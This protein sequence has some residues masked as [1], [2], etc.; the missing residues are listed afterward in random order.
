MLGHYA[1]LGLLEGDVLGLGEGDRS[2]SEEVAHEGALELAGGGDDAAS[3][4]DG[5]LDGGEDV[6]DGAL[7]GERR[8]GNEKRLQNGLWESL[9][10][11]CPFHTGRQL[12]SNR[13]HLQIESEELNS[14]AV[15][16]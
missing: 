8:E 9:S 15:W 6:G 2:I 12:P 1:D 13:G 16:Q 4:L 3:G 11:R 7:L 14:N 5:A 10:S